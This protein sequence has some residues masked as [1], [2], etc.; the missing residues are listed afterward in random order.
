MDV[1]KSHLTKMTHQ[2]SGLMSVQGPLCRI[3]EVFHAEFVGP[4]DHRS[5]AHNDRRYEFIE[6]CTVCNELD[7]D[8]PGLGCFS[9]RTA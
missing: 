7:V 2:R 3:N 1:G 9:A 4:T 8:G 6:K 5:L